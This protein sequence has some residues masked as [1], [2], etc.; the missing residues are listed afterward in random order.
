M[1]YN[2]TDILLF[3]KKKGDELGKLN[4]WIGG[5]CMIYYHSTS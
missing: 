1:A 2:S 5:E 4:G 3:F